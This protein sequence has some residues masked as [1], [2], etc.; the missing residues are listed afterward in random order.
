MGVLQFRRGTLSDKPSLKD[1]EPYYAMDENA[2]YIGNEKLG[3]QK[4]IPDDGVKIFRGIIRSATADGVDLIVL[5]NDFGC[6]IT[7]E[8][9]DAGFYHLTFEGT[10]FDEL[11][12]M[13]R[14]NQ[15]VDFSVDDGK[16]INVYTK[17]HD[18]KVDVQVGDGD[19]GQDNMLSYAPIEVIEYP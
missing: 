18:S 5:R 8:R 13:A 14:C 3:D 10:T 6:N 17:V 7:A 15:G 12:T 9:D 1:G 16:L 11:K 19:S 2:I 4:F